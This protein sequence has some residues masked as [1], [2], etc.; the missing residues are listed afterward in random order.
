MGSDVCLRLAFEISVSNFFDRLEIMPVG[1]IVGPFKLF[2]PMVSD[3]VASRSYSLFHR[4]IN[5]PSF[6]TDHEELKWEAARHALTLAFGKSNY[7]PA[8][9]DPMNVLKFLG[10]HIARQCTRRG[11]GEKAKIEEVEKVEL[12]KSHEGAVRCAFGAFYNVDNVPAPVLIPEHSRHLL[13]ELLSGIR[14]LIESDGRPLALRKAAIHFLY[15]VAD[16]WLSSSNPIPTS[17]QLIA[18][19]TTSWAKSV[20]DMNRAYETNVRTNLTFVLR[21]L[22]SKAWRPYLEISGGQL[23]LILDL[24]LLEFDLTERTNDR[25]VLP[26][27][28][29]V[30]NRD[31]IKGRPKSSWRHWHVLDD[32]SLRALVDQTRVSKAKY[33]EDLNEFGEVMGYK[34]EMRRDI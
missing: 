22:R 6:G 31:A 3:T 13:A 18:R 21:V 11:T 2:P 9:E 5:L 34:E 16:D 15:Y 28:V 23:A 27:L 17:P 30:E 24:R 26:Y 7:N 29:E 33:P 12:E 20:V 4:P 25:N 14:R 10:Y 1:D 19:L 32:P 8:L